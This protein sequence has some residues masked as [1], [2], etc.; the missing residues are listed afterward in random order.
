[1]GRSG[2]DFFEAE[3]YVGIHWSLLVN[4]IKKKKSFMRHIAISS[5][6]MWPDIAQDWT[7]GVS[8]MGQAHLKT[9]KDKHKHFINCSSICTSTL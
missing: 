6:G 9:L 7:A 8:G 3:R 2:H 1:M 4:L 5:S